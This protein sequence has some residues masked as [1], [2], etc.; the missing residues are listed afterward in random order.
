LTSRPVPPRPPLAPV[1][2]PL[3]HPDEG[4][5][6]DVPRTFRVIGEDRYF[7]GLV[8]VPIEF[9]L[10]HLRRERG[11]L[12]GELYVRTELIGARTFQGTLSAASFNVSS[13]AA[14]QARA[15]ILAEAARTPKEQIDWTFLLEEFCIRVL[16]AERTGAAAADLREIPVTNTRVALHNV[17]GLLLPKAHP[18]M[19]YGDGGT[20]KSLVAAYCAGRL[21]QQGER[22]GFFD[23]ELDAAD[24]AQ[25]YRALFGPTGGPSITYVR[26]NRALVHEADRLR[27]V[28]QDEKLTYA[29][30]DSVAF[31]CHGKPEDA[32]I[33]LQYFRVLRQLGIGTLNLAHVPKAPLPG[34]E[35]PFGSQFWFNG[36]RSLW[37]CASQPNPMNVA[38]L[39]VGFYQRKNNLG[40]PAPAVGF[41]FDFG[42][43]RTTV[44]RCDPAGVEELAA[45][46]PL[47]QRMRTVLT[48]GPQTLIALSQELEA[49]VDT[50]D[51]LVR[52][53]S[54]LFT[55]INGGDGISRIALVSSR[56]ED[57]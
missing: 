17:E 6:S 28:V 34:Q 23:W 33:A 19:L 32:E 8:G 13:S 1:V 56:S 39:A 52:R 14:R 22:V 35:R 37:F 53:K 31:A 7:M 2:P 29:V 46:L 21:G 36:I 57:D 26:C 9:D 41:Q 30:L 3:P 5:A 43:D 15:K 11:E 51:R 20:G 48:S 47:W 55:R 4:G 54:G 27:R 16:E 38:R 12:M 18:S 50:L 45:R 24:Q 40:H 10:E 25:R 49:K 44:T 42:E